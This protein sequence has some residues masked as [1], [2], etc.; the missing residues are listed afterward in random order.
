MFFHVS[1]HAL[2]DV[3]FLMR[4]HVVIDEGRFVTN[5]HLFFFSFY[6]TKKSLLTTFCTV[7]LFK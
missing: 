7:Y 3:L 2:C 4:W 5:N 1:L 6:L